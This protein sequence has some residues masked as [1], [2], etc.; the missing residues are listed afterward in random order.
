MR[1]QKVFIPVVK[2]EPYSGI[3]VTVSKSPSHLKLKQQEGYFF[4]PDQLE[5]QLREA[6]QKGN[7]HGFAEGSDIEGYTHNDSENEYIKSLK[8][9]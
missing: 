2:N 5:K 3:M 6:F 9:K 7:F 4:T 8:I 1:K